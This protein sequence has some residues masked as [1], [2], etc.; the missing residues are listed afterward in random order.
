MMNLAMLMV[1][2]TIL[3]PVIVIAYVCEVE[4]EQVNPIL[5]RN[6]NQSESRPEKK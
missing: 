2:K 5:R 6:N 3:Q 1:K 4:T